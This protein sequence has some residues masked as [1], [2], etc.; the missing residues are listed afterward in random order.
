MEHDPV[1]AFYE[2]VDP[3]HAPQ[4][5]RCQC[6]RISLARK[7][8]REAYA[9]H[10]DLLAIEYDYMNPTENMEIVWTLNEVI[11]ILRADE[12]ACCREDVIDG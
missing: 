5:E 3:E 8:E 12:G 2:V 6:I 11:R 9:R 10:L 4:G 1:C 7:H